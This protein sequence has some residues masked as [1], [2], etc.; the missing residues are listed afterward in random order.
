MTVKKM[1]H[2]SYAT[3]SFVTRFVAIGEYSIRVK[4]GN[5]LSCVTL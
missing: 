2:L 4:I 1:G 5:F 3:S